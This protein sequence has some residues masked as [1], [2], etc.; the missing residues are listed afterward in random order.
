M[1]AKALLQLDGKI[2][3][4]TG[5]PRCCGLQMAQATA[6]PETLSYGGRRP[7]AERPDPQHL[8]AHRQ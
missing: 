6:H 5:S 3:V 4:I 8:L 1:S 7:A 2:A